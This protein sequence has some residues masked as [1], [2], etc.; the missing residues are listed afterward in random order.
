MVKRAEIIEEARKWKGT[1]H[2][3]QGRL[4]G[5]GC[6]CVGIVIGVG[7]ILLHKEDIFPKTYG[8]NAEKYTIKEHFDKYLIPKRKEDIKP[9][10]VILMKMLYNPQHA[11]IVSTYSD[12][13]MGLIHCY[14][15]VKK[16]VEH[17]LDSKWKSRIIKAY[18]Y[19]EVED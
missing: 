15:G 5:L 19:P 7:C 12:K 4:K 17:R 14:D 2:R 18:E 9:G 13:S 3:H 1:P 8:R 6:D 16:V 11:G 10:D